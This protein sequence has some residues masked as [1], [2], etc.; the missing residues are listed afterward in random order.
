MRQAQAKWERRFRNPAERSR[1]DVPF[2]QVRLCAGQEGRISGAYCP[3]LYGPASSP[4]RTPDFL[5]S[6][7]ALAHFMRLSL[8]KAAHVV[9]GR[10]PC[11]KSGYLGRK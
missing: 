6:L 2:D 9:F 7:L 3:P 5:L 8:R 11:R 10:A 1:E 4:Q